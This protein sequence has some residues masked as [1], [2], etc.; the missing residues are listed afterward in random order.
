MNTRLISE[1]QQIAKSQ[2][3]LFQ[4]YTFNKSLNVTM[5]SMPLFIILKHPVSESL[6]AC[7]SEDIQVSSVFLLKGWYFI[8]YFMCKNKIILTQK[9]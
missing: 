8:N 9:C 3:Q 1:H 7:V 5:I 4:P 2:V 6:P